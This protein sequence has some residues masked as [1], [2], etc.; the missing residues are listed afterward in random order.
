MPR[1]NIIPQDPAEDAQLTPLTGG[2]LKPER[3]SGALSRIAEAAGPQRLGV[4]S[5]PSSKPSW[6]KAKPLTLLKKA[7]VDD[8]IAAIMAASLNH[9]QDNIPAALH[10]EDT[11]GV[12]QTRVALRRLRSALAYSKN[13]FPSIS[14]IGSAPKRSGYS[15]NS[16]RHG[17]STSSSKT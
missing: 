3:S 12:H 15:H 9:F 6:S 16:A 2:D 7:S 10:G 4:P 5:A 8:A 1:R 13:T 11:E 14:A 17:I